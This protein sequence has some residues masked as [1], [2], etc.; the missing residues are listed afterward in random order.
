MN[1]KIENSIN[2]QSQKIQTNVLNILQAKVE[3]QSEALISKRCDEYQN[4]TENK[5]IKMIDVNCLKI[6]IN[7]K[8]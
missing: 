5:L 3:E 4:V 1:L 6:Q 2:D 7:N 8:M